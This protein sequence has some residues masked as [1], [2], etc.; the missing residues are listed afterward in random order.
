[1][2]RTDR[3]SRSFQT[4]WTG[5]WVATNNHNFLISISLRRISLQNHNGPRPIIN[6]LF[7]LTMIS[8]FKVKTFYCLKNRGKRKFSVST[9]FLRATPFRKLIELNFPEVKTHRKNRIVYAWK[10]RK[11]A[12]VGANCD[13]IIRTACLLTKD[14]FQK[15][16]ERNVIV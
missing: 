16:F 10:W 2:R 7:N 15:W 12:Y 5:S 11:T 13:R 1:M 14:L 8:P 4:K 6:T 3:N 9:I